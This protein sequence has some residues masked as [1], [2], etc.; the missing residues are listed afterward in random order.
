[1]RGIKRLEASDKVTKFD[2][3]YLNKASSEAHNGD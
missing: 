1:M 2:C 3:Y